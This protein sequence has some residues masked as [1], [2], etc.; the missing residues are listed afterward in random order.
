MHGSFHGVTKLMKRFQDL[1]PGMCLSSLLGIGLAL[2]LY[3]LQSPFLDFHS[4]RQADT[5]AI[6]RYFFERDSNILHPQLPYYGPPPNYA[7]LEFALIP[8]ITA[9]LYG[10]SGEQEWVARLVVIAFSMLAP[11]GIYYIGRLLW[12]KW[13]GVATAGVLCLSPF[14]IYFSRSYQP[15]VPMLALGTAALAFWFHY[16]L[17]GSVLSFFSALTLFTLA[18]L[19]KPPALL[20]CFPALGI[21]LDIRF[22]KQ[23]RELNKAYSWWTHWLPAG[24]LFVLPLT[25]MTL[26]FRQLRSIAEHPFASSIGGSLIRRLL[27]QGP[28]EG[29]ALAVFIGLTFFV[30]SVVLLA[31]IAIGGVKESRGPWLWTLSLWGFGLTVYLLIAGASILFYLQYYFL[32]IMPLAALLAARGLAWSVQ[33]ITRIAILGAIIPLFLLLIIWLVPAQ[34][35]ENESWRVEKWYQVDW[36]IYDRAMAIKTILG[37][38]SLVIVAEES[39]RTLFYSRRF[40]WF[41]RPEE[42]NGE[43]MT[44]ARGEGATHIIWFDDQV[45]AYV[46]ENGLLQDEKKREEIEDYP[47]GLRILPLQ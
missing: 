10:L 22:N 16:V 45:P 1:L 40:G 23:K 5:A 17:K 29:W 9:W 2:R 13:T 39:P 41:A 3:G 24:I 19:V 15:D 36:Q 35:R 32:P 25:I 14:F 18:V 33:N 31:P 6:A 30:S 37:P 4:W 27:E 43:F 42:I 26:Y 12:N 28:D 20:F 47:A 34:W 44:K 11:L 46:W 21:L 7:E 8:W 38:E